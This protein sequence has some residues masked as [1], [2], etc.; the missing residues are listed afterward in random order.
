[1][2]VMTRKDLKEIVPILEASDNPIAS[3][4]LKKLKK[5]LTPIKISSRKG[6]GRNLQKFVC[7]KISEFTGIPYGNTDEHLIR[8][9]E[10]GQQGVDVILLGEARKKFPFSIECKNTETF[11][12]YKTIEQAKAN[13]KDGDMWMIIHKKNNSDPVVLMDFN[14]FLTFLNLRA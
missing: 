1:M 7:E 11:Q 5:E 3:R 9:R 13:V 12:M 2:K 4:I 6:K 14:D 10:M 8:S